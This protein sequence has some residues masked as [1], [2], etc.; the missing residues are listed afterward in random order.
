MHAYTGF[1]QSLVD[2]LY[3]HPVE[4][5]TLI[6]YIESEL[7]KARLL[8]VTSEEALIICLTYTTSPY[9]NYNYLGLVYKYPY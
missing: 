4:N 1:T 3:K 6:V 7:E 2:F 8:A 5:S 9:L